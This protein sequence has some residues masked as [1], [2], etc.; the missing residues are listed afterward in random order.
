MQTKKRS[1]LRRTVVATGLTATA[2]ALLL[3]GTA[4]AHID[5]DPIAV[6]ADTSNTVPSGWSTVVTA[7]RP[8]ELQIQ[9]PATVA[10]AQPVDKDGW[11]ASVDGRR[12]SRSPVDRWRPT[13]RTTSPSRS[14]RPR[15]A[16]PIAFPIVQLCEVGQLDWIESAVEG[17]EEPEHPA[18]SVLVTAEAPT[19]A[20]LAHRPRRGDR[21]KR[22]RPTPARTDTTPVAEATVHDTSP[23]DDTV[24]DAES[25]P[26]DVDSP[27]SRGRRRRDGRRQQH[28]S[29]HRRRSSSA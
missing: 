8:T 10:D 6:Q 3:A 1:T 29:R 27:T 5:P 13:H 18:P 12:S 11:T 4:S 20:E 19:D 25:S 7:R 15:R 28:R 2:G 21:A 9:V 14:R 24:P 26:V 16:G 17:G 22:P 23:S